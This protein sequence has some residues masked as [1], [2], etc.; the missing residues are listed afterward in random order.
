MGLFLILLLDKIPSD[1]AMLLALAI[2]M[3]A[4]IITT[5]EGLAGFSSSAGKLERLN[6]FGFSK[7][8][9]QF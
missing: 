2:L 9:C 8:L 4:Q 6:D 7:H 3:S 5:A 1:F